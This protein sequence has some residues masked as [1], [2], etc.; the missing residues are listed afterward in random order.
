[1]VISVFMAIFSVYVVAKQKANIEWCVCHDEL[2]NEWLIDENGILTPACNYFFVFE[3]EMMKF[4]I[5]SDSVIKIET[6]LF[7]SAQKGKMSAGGEK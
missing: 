6:N 1:M 7:H 4:C 2:N 3:E 5:E